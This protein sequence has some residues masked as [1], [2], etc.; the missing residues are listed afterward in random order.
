MNIQ[1]LTLSHLVVVEWQRDNDKSQ[2][3]VA[4]DNWWCEAK[5]R[6]RKKWSELH[7]QMQ[8]QIDCW[9]CQMEHCFCKPHSIETQQKRFLFFIWHWE[10]N[11]TSKVIKKWSALCQHHSVKKSTILDTLLKFSF[12]FRASLWLNFSNRLFV[13]PIW[14]AHRLWI[15]WSLRRDPPPSFWAHG[16]WMLMHLSPQLDVSC[17][18][19]HANLQQWMCVCVL[20]THMGEASLLH[21]TCWM[22]WIMDPAAQ[23]V[24]SS[25]MMHRQFS[26]LLSGH[27]DFCAFSTCP[28]SDHKK[29]TNSDFMLN[30]IRHLFRWQQWKAT[31]N[32]IKNVPCL[33]EL[34]AVVVVRIR[35]QTEDGPQNRNMCV[36]KWPKF[37]HLL[38]CQI[39][40]MDFDH[41]LFLWSSK[42]NFCSCCRTDA[43]HQS[44]RNVIFWQWRLCSPSSQRMMPVRCFP[45]L[46][47]RSLVQIAM[48]RWSSA[49]NDSN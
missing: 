43:N 17:S 20:P 32:A 13:I 11:W 7:D 9:F 46:D 28:F 22:L 47:C 5:E 23:C 1:L 35:V 10:C 29:S 14:S 44:P 31:Q 41:Q 3:N 26:E 40:V 12:L 42:M 39:D 45:L 38:C 21:Q 2:V 6:Q 48:D 49:F 19:W 15:T 8:D 16:L 18:I 34:S 36:L 37:W 24:L 25:A 27:N 33:K 30:A 4:F